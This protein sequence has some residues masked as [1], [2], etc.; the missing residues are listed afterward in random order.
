MKLLLLSVLLGLTLASSESVYTVDGQTFQHIFGSGQASASQV[1]QVQTNFANTNLPKP[2]GP[3]PVEI[4]CP[5]LQ[6]YDNIL[7]KCVCIFGYYMAGDKCVPYSV[8]PVCGNNEVYQDGR[9]VCDIGYYLIGDKCD[10]C[11]PYSV[12]DIASLS[13]K[14][15]EGYVRVNGN[16]ARVYTPPVLPPVPQPPTC[17]INEELVGQVCQCRSGFF[18]IKGVCTYCA[19]PNFYDAQLAICRPRCGSNEVLD[20]N[21]VT[22]ICEG[23]FVKVDG[24]CGSCPAYSIYNSRTSTCDCVQ[25]YELNAGRCIPITFAPVPE[26]PLPVAPSPCGPNQNFVNQ[27]CI[28][29]VGFNLVGGQCIQ[30]ADGQFFDASLKICRIPCAANEVY[31]VNFDRCDCARNT[32]NISGACTT[33]PGN[34]TYDPIQLQ[35]RCPDGYT[36]RGNF[37]VIGCG[38][39]E[40]LSNGKCCCITGYYPVEGVCSQCEWNE[41]YD[42]GLGIC[43]VPCDADRIYDISTRQC[44]CLP[45]YF[46]MHDGLCKKC[47]V[48]STYN[49]ITK[50]CICDSGYVKSLGRCV[51]NCNAY[52]NWVDGKCICKPG[53]NLIGYNC[54]VCPPQLHYDATYRICRQECLHNE[55]WDPLIRACRCLPAFYYVNGVCSQ[56][57]M[58]NQVYNQESGCCDCIEGYHKIHGQGCK[59]QCVPKCNVNE[60]WVGDRC[61]CK[62][63]FYLINNFCTKCPEGQFYDIYTSQCRVKCSTNQV[64]DHDS[65]RC[66]CARGYYLV[67]GACS[68]CMDGETYDEFTQTCRRVPCLGLNEYFSE[69]TQQCICKTPYVRVRGVCTLCPPGYYYD[70]YAG[71]CLCKPGYKQVGGLCEPLCKWD[72]EYVNGRCQCRNGWDLVGDRCVEPG[73]NCPP[74]AVLDKAKKCCVCAPGYAVIG[75]RCSSYEYCGINANL[76]Y[77]Q[78]ECKPGYFWIRGSC[79]SCPANS[80][81]NG[82]SCECILGY[83]RNVNGEC[84]VSNFIPNCYKNER[85]DSALKACVCVAG[86]QFLNGQCIEIPSCPAN[87]HY[88]GVS[89]VCVTGFLLDNGVCKDV[90]TIVPTPACPQNAFFNGVS[91]TCNSGFYQSAIDAC[92]P[93]A[94]G[95]M[96]DGYECAATIT[97]GSGFQLNSNSNQCEPIAP[98][99][100]DNARW[101]G[102]MCVCSQNAHLINGRCQ[103]CPAGKVFDGS[104]CADEVVVNTP[105]CGSNQVF[106]ND[107]CVCSDGYH[108]IGDQC[109][110]CPTNTEWN[111]K[112]CHCTDSNAAMWCF[113]RPYTNWNGG[114]CGCERGYTLV[115]GLCSN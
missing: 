43:R 49:N 46:E 14:C 8:P 31:N 73:W 6:V 39:N 15:I 24:V 76:R 88:N 100:G 87:S 27:R 35:C 19:E 40:I 23:S 29:Q 75:G 44:V 72:Q 34:T 66:V 107:K 115:N 56:C 96:W 57:N 11:A 95:T 74:N 90:S 65:S 70:H 25:G 94:S 55:V 13:C 83:V 102:A 28:C 62:P 79:Q 22:C 85:Y 97:C 91:C 105:S 18:L 4:D 106:V 33:C 77:G 104:Q 71:Q 109:L 78:C 51:R 10:T 54:G 5:Y 9:C 82:V 110:S 37:C 84:V 81:Y 16:C 68:R 38:I 26:V 99:C 17:G 41:V 69:V 112:Y 60:D 1:A 30:C 3:D 80:A 7:C 61:V 63:G 21:S 48:H 64:Y 92:A 93:C 47:T 114:S 67:Q 45:Q 50:E 2:K 58:T 36:N 42:Q 103:V 89:C 108:M 53:Y 113:G 52:E 20:L 98:S 12:Y 59:G 111:G 32:F 101:N 86:T